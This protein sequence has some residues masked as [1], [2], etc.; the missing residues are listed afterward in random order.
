MRWSVLHDSS[1]NSL[2]FPLKI[3]FYYS[4][5]ALLLTATCP[6]LHFWGIC[7]QHSWKQ[8]LTS[9]YFLHSYCLFAHFR[10]LNCALHKRIRS[11]RKNPDYYKRAKE[12]HLKGLFSP[13]NM[14]KVRHHI[15]SPLTV[16]LHMTWF[17]EVENW[18][19]RKKN[20]Q[21]NATTNPNYIF[22]LKFIKNTEAGE[23]CC[24]NTVVS[25]TMLLRASQY[26]FETTTYCLTWQEPVLQLW[27]DCWRASPWDIKKLPLHLYCGV[28]QLHALLEASSWYLSVSSL[29]L[30]PCR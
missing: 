29:F 6:V 18:I 24:L 27:K 20:Q 17:A 23:L 8:F 2:L 25:A 11:G 10:S 3:I 22:H 16:G 7:I 28:S 13:D 30:S 5:A 19:G 9:V 4:A 1:K 14:D 12:H 26:S 15:L 21:G